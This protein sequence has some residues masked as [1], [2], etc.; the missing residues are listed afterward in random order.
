V[1]PLLLDDE[2]VGL[3]TGDDV[4]VEEVTPIPLLDEEELEYVGP[5]ELDVGDVE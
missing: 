2:E 3:P 4:D 5:T 1:I